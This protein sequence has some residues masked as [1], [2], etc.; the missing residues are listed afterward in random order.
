MPSRFRF[1]W[2]FADS[3]H[4]LLSLWVFNFN[5]FAEFIGS[6][7]GEAAKR[8][9]PPTSAVKALNPRA[10]RTRGRRERKGDVTIPMWGPAVTRHPGFRRGTRR[11]K[12]R[13]E[14]H[15]CCRLA[16]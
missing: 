2:D 8:A 16:G 5:V 6:P 13:R 11:A 9:D 14:E 10:G 12:Q 3:W 1:P 7:L 4:L 15:F